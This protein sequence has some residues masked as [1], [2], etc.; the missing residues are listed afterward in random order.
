[1]VLLPVL[2]KLGI[3]FGHFG[4]RQGIVLKHSSIRC[5]S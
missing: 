1:M 5:G 4:L 2:V 3:D